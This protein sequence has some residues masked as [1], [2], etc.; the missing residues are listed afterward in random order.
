MYNKE[1]F[2]EKLKTEA[3][4][5]KIELNNNQLESFYKYKEILLSWNEKI[6]LTAITD[7]KE[8][9]TKHFIDSLTI[10]KHIKENAKIIDIG[11][12]AGFPAIPIKILN[13]NLDITLVDSLNK[14]V[15]FL[16]ILVDELKLENI[17]I[18][19][20]RAEDLSIKKEYRE[21][22]DIVLSR[23]VA[24]MNVLAEYLIPF[25]K[26]NGICI[27]MKGKNYKEELKT[28]KKAIDLLGGKLEE[29]EETSLPGTEEQRT[30]IIITKQNYTP[31][32]YPRKAGTA[33]KTPIV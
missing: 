26:L 14:R 13:K 11:T 5:L 12:G 3:R 17:K 21:K 29:P 9:I 22:Y 25:A 18:I 32:Q 1:E 23:A 16:K 10:A 2:K 6:N 27:C 7:E 28:S 24:A 19:H 33:S 31:R 15:E 8:I 20:S 30:I 4:A